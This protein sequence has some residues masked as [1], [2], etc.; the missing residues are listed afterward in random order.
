MEED[1]L[2]HVTYGI[3]GGFNG[4]KHRYVNTKKAIDNFGCKECEKYQDLSI[5]TYS[6]ENSKIRNTVT[7][8]EEIE[9]IKKVLKNAE[10]E[11]ETSKK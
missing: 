5:G 2:L 1:D 6:F 4:L 7:N 10:K 9:Y 8:T 11:Y 3:N